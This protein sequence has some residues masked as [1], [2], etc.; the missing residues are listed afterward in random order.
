[1]ASLTNARDIINRSR[2]TTG[3]SGIDILKFPLDIDNIPHKFIMNFKKRNST[4]SM[5]DFGAAVRADSNIRSAIALPVPQ[6]IAEKFSLNYTAE[7]MGIIGEAVR[8]IAAGVTT[9]ASLTDVASSIASFTGRV[10][11]DPVGA[12]QS[13]GGVTA[14]LLL[15]AV[16]TLA[17]TAQGTGATG[18]LGDI[19]RA[20]YPGLTVGLGAIMNPYTTAIFKG[21]NL[22]K[23]EFA[24]L[25]APNNERESEALENIIRTIRYYMLP[26]KN[27]ITLSYPDEVEYTITGMEEKYRIPTKA[28]V[29]ED[30]DVSRT[31]IKEA[32]PAFFA[33]TGAPA[34]IQLTVKLMEVTPIYQDDLL[35]ANM[36][37]EGSQPSI[38]QPAQQPSSTGT[39]PLIGSTGRVAGPV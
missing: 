9:A 24:W 8:G 20:G 23:N 35:A 13:G 32:G 29:I 39:P 1:M 11:T 28:C 27:L 2:A 25:L 33:K 3:A 36:G 34:F 12:F 15:A 22:R 30:F 31:P 7:D 19:A 10:V 5:T 21:V 17:A 37:P 38:T 6:D 16:G 4:I 18:V 26:K 14:D